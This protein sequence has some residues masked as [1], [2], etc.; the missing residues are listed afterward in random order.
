MNPLFVVPSWQLPYDKHNEFAEKYVSHLQG[1]KD[2]E[3]SMT[4]NVST[5]TF[6]TNSVIHLDPVFNDLVEFILSAGTEIRKEYN[7]SS[8]INFG[9]SNMFASIT[10]PN[11]LFV[12]DH[13][14]GNFISGV[15][16]LKTPANSGEYG[17]THDIA[18]RSYFK[19]TFV[20]SRNLINSES[21]KVPMPES[22]IIF[23]PTYLKTFST[24][25]L[26]TDDRILI[27]F[28]LKLC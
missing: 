26:S 22:G 2:N 25:N 11:G 8:S 12:N 23:Y 24:G 4:A 9:L 13:I 3:L 16:F 21:I 27:H 7:L 10:G 6:L 1:Y 20:E 19:Q 15:Y 14:M 17:F 5:N 18:D 28:G